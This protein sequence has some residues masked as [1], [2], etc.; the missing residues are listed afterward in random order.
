M[1]YL[2]DLFSLDGKVAVT[3]G[4]GGVLGGAMATALGRAG[5]RVAVLD[6]IDEAAVAQANMIYGAAGVDAMGIGVDATNVDDLKSALDRI[7]D[8]R[9]CVRRGM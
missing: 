5:A 4:A 3:I 6:L 2:E 1:S 8:P 9:G 7:V